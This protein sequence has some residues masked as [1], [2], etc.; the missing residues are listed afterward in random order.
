MFKLRGVCRS[1]KTRHFFWLQ[2]HFGPLHDIQLYKKATVRKFPLPISVTGDL[3]VNM[4]T[5][6]FPVS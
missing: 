6:D 5:N 2:K 1:Y 4:L 3:W